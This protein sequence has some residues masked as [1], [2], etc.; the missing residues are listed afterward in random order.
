MMLY[1]VIAWCERPFYAECEV[2]AETPE[3]ALAKA[4]EAIHGEPAE[5]CGGE[6]C[7][8]EWRVETDDEEVLSHLDEPA[9]LGLAAPALLAACQMVVDR[10]EKGDLAEAV[11]ACAAA[12]AEVEGRA[13]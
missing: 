2:E 7:W 1:T 4:R 8:D 10:W 11:R 13:A 12:I 6:Y 5:D 3:A 9:R